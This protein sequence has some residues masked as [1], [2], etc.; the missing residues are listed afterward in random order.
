M[1]KIEQT[2]AD[3]SRA[4]RLQWWHEARFGMFVHWGLYSQLGRHEWA[5]NRERI[6]VAEYERLA[7]SW[8]VKP[9]PAR[10][11]ARV[12]RQAG[13]RYLV[14]TTKHHEGFCLWDTRMTDYNAVRRAPG[15]DLVA[16]YVEACRQQGLRVG[17]YYS[18]MDWHHPDG[19]RCATSAKARRRFVDF[20]CGCVRELMS[21]Y[22]KIDILWY[23]VPWPLP[24]PEEWESAKM[25][26]MVR[27]LQPDIII[28]NRS[29]LPEDF[30]TPE[31]HIQAAETG[32]AWEACMTF[33]GS[34][35]YMPY[36]PA[37]DWHSSRSVLNMLRQ[38]TA[39]GG[40][41]L[42]NI[43]PAPDG[44]V[45]PEAV[46]RL[47]PVGRWLKKYGQAVYGDVDRTDECFEWCP[48]GGWT[49]RGLT[50]YFWCS[51]W[52]GSQLTIGGFS[53][54]VEAV[55]LLHNGADVEFEQTEPQLKLK[56]LPPRN[57]DR[58]AQICVLQVTF[59]STPRQRL[60]T[61]YVL[62]D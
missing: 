50:G 18:L 11:W 46:E 26:K 55:K 40:N 14:M 32:R 10:E 29:Q 30:G 27:K 47:A 48:L 7:D 1:P 51:R 2:K 44:S 5:M 42:L 33:N 54:K 8:E 52:P 20:T 39:G 3:R 56:G 23:D 9:W 13:M 62:L 17:F 35:G 25:N 45:P 60:G 21:N 31:E 43:G 24:S 37:E 41:L 19:A 4:R 57:P 53:S 59:A 6:P 58:L 15:R 12:A 36:A 49:R 28:N 61:G 16:E 38:V 34:W 22:G